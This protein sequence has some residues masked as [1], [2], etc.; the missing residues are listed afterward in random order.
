VQSTNLAQQRGTR[1][2]FKSPQLHL[3]KRYAQGGEKDLRFGQVNDLTTG[4]G[5]KLT[6]VDLCPLTTNLGQKCRTR[7][8]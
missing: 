8:N 3:A 7:E 6:L 5:L 1:R 4:F 2:S